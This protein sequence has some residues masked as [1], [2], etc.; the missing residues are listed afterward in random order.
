M[1]A[2]VRPVRSILRPPTMVLVA[3]L[4]LAACAPAAAPTPVP[5]AEPTAAPTA[6]PTAQPT[7]EPTAAPTPEPTA[8]PTV[9]PT[10]A[11][12]PAPTA[13]PAASAA[14]TTGSG[15]SPSVDRLAFGVKGSRL[16]VVNEMNVAVSVGATT[17]LYYG[18]WTPVTPTEVAPGKTWCQEGYNDCSAAIDGRSTKAAMRDV[19]AFVSIGGTRSVAVVVHNP[20]QTDPW[21]W[22]QRNN[23]ALG[24]KA[25]YQ[26][27]NDPT[28]FY[29]D[30]SRLSLDR[31]AD[32]SGYKEFRLTITP[33]G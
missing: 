14:A 23:D 12:T 29:L 30:R 16:C 22:F 18:D 2:P 10:A 31:V 33:F 17:S 3:V 9:A 6:E 26:R 28:I 27:T 20:W 24:F 11:P 8:A 15:P 25:Y 5:T 19:C 1:T 21:A 7:A 13:A 4:A 32:T